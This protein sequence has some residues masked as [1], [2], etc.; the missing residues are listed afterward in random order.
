ME[1]VII[2]ERSGGVAQVRFNRPDALNALNM[3][4][5]RTLDRTLAG[6]ET[7]STV[8]S[9]ILTGAG[10]AFMA[11]GDVR[12]F[13]ETLDQTPADRRAYFNRL[14]DHAHGAV[15]R[16]WRMPKPVIAAI[17]GPVAGFGIGLAAACDFSIATE[18]AAFS[19]AYCHLGA[20]PDGGATMILPQLCGLKR[21]SELVMLGDRFSANEAH[22]LGIVNQVVATD[23][24]PSTTDALSQRLAAG[25]LGAHAAAKALL[26]GPLTAAFMAQLLME[27][28]QF[29]TRAD[30]AEFA[31]G[32][33]AFAAKRRPDFTA[34]RT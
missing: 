4:L 8:R 27:K 10:R 24:L 15:Q 7:D 16:I 33:S 9:I 30:S 31:E 25:P 23:M 32:L 20:T 12:E 3:A 34:T 1:D 21:A 17:N 5:A 26:R 14:I 18:G 22:Q 11:G 13:V 19:L 6:L 28:D 2:V 29:A